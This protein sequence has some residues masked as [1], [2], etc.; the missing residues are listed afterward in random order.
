MRTLTLVITAGLLITAGLVAAVAAA[1]PDRTSAKPALRILDRT[2]FTVQGR[3]FRA[4]ERV[5]VTLYKET[6]AVRTRRV[7]A[8]RAGVFTAALSETR[9]DRCDTIMIRAVGT[10]GSVAQL[11]LLPR[12]ACKSD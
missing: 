6:V 5:K 9:I 7:R 4:L 3:H 10:S 1:G 8:S 2:P 12:P 11:K